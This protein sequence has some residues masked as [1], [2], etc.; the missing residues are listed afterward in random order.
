MNHLKIMWYQISEDL[1][2][3]I[4]HCVKQRW[5]VF[6]VYGIRSVLGFLPAIPYSCT[7]SVFYVICYILGK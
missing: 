7:Q 2:L 3:N 4:C 6:L 1:G 5:H